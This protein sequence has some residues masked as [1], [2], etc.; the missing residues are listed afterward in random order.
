M[1]TVL[2][3]YSRQA[4]LI[5]PI[6]REGAPPSAP[7][8]DAVELGHGLVPRCVEK[9]GW[10]EHSKTKYKEKRPRKPPCARPRSC[11]KSGTVSGNTNGPGSI[12]SID[13]RCPASGDLVLRYG[14]V[15]I[16]SA[17]R[18]RARGKAWRHHAAKKC[19]QRANRWPHIEKV[20]LD[21]IK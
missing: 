1:T 15:T 20:E 3:H 14:V 16:S 12:L 17:G 2:Y 13:E 5:S 19:R 8:R 7:I 10:G 11:S 4:P 21:K 9:R 18:V 6:T